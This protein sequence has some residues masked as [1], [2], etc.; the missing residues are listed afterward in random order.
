MPCRRTTLPAWP[1]QGKAS[2]RRYN[3]GDNE[4]ESVASWQ[5]RGLPPGFGRLTPE[6]KEVS[7]WSSTAPES[8]SFRTKYDSTY[9]PGGYASDVAISHLRPLLL[10]QSAHRTTE[11]RAPVAGF[12]RIHFVVCVTQ[13]MASRDHWAFR[14]VWVPIVRSHPWHRSCSLSHSR[15]VHHRHGTLPAPVPKAASC[16]H[17]IRSFFDGSAGI[18]SQLSD[19]S[20]AC[21]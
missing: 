14:A 9:P 4:A 20:Q 10:G 15:P 13:G 3:A 5:G 11:I 21:C 19:G 16:H 6:W 2:R 7:S 17:H 8:V 12:R 18:H 1:A